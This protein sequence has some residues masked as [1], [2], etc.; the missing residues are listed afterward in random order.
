MLLWLDPP[1]WGSSPLTAA[2][3]LP[4]GKTARN[5]SGLLADSVGE[6]ALFSAWHTGPGCSERNGAVCGDLL[7]ES[8]C[9]GNLVL[10][11]C[12]RET[13]TRV[14]YCGH[15]GFKTA[16][17]EGNQGG[18]LLGCSQ[19]RLTESCVQPVV[20]LPKSQFYVFPVFAGF[21]RRL[22]FS[23][24]SAAST[25]RGT[26]VIFLARPLCYCFGLSEFSYCWAAVGYKSV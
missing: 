6:F 8:W 22:F 12:V 5:G 23:S 9:H 13:F 15:E 14:C 4:A 7:L 16:L 25:C 20:L 1:H 19:V 11:T 24:L 3:G 10:T 2:K 17:A 21:R 26:T 18:W